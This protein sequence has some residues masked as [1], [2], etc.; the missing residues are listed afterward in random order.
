MYETRKKTMFIDESV[1]D[2]DP[3]NK[4]AHYAFE[5][6]LYFVGDA[7][8]SYDIS[9]LTEQNAE[10]LTHKIN[11]IRIK[12]QLRQSLEFLPSFIKSWKEFEATFTDVI[13]T[14]KQKAID[15]IDDYNFAFPIYSITSPNYF[16]YFEEMY[17]E[18]LLFNN[19]STGK[20][21]SALTA[22]MALRDLQLDDALEKKYHDHN[23]VWRQ[24][25]GRCEFH[26]LVSVFENVRYFDKTHPQDNAIEWLRNYFRYASAIEA[27][28]Q[29]NK[30]RELVGTRSAIMAMFKTYNVDENYRIAPTPEKNYLDVYEEEKRI[31]ITKA[32]RALL[33]NAI[34]A[35][36]SVIRAEIRPSP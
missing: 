22:H 24:I 28:S 4:D 19:L 30:A 14:N 8:D 32:H 6:F 23:A 1:F 20:S 2:F 18:S 27:I 12:E 16:H 11:S 29:H 31:P 25:A 9:L 15:K 35:I 13:I 5:N 33:N 26:S 36:H 21:I 17:D 3:S 7:R 10:T 34:R